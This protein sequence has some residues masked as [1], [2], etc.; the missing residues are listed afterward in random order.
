[1]VVWLPKRLI[2]IAMFAVAFNQGPA[3]VSAQS[4]EVNSQVSNDSL[5]KIAG[6]LSVGEEALLLQVDIICKPYREGS[7][8]LDRENLQTPFD[9][10]PAKV[11]KD[12]ADRRRLNAD[13]IKR[14]ALKEDTHA[15]APSGIRIIGAIF[16]DQLDLVGLE[17]RYSLV[18]DRSLFKS[19]INARNFRTKGDFS[20]D[21]SVVLKVLWLV[22]ARIDGTVFASSTF[23][24]NLHALESEVQRSLLFRNSV[25]FGIVEFDNLTVSGELSVR[26]SALSRF[27]MQSS[28]IG[29]VLDLSGSEARCAYHIK[30]SDFGNIIATDVGL[31]QV[32]AGA[33]QT[34]SRNYR[35]GW[36]RATTNSHVMQILQRP[37]VSSIVGDSDECKKSE[38]LLLDNHVRS[39]MCL[40][41][42]HWLTSHGDEVP[43]YLT[44]ND[45]NLGRSLIVNLGA[46]ASDLNNDAVANRVKAQFEAVGIEARNFIFDFAEGKPQYSLIVDGL[47]FE[48]AYSASI[49]CG[50]EPA[51]PENFASGADFV[52]EPRSTLQL[53][54]VRAVMDW[55]RNNPLATTQPLTAF[56]EAYHRAGD[57]VSSMELRIARADKELRTDTCVWL[58]QVGHVI[59]IR[60]SC[61]AS[62]AAKD[63]QSSIWTGLNWLWNGLN[64]LWAG[65]VIAFRWVLY[66]IA[67]HGYRPVQVVW[68]VL[69][70]LVGFDLY[71]WTLLGIIGFKSNGNPRVKPI[72]LLFLFDRLI[73]AYKIRDEHYNIGE[74]YKRAVHPHQNEILSKEVQPSV[75]HRASTMRYLGCEWQV[76]EAGER[77][78]RRVEVALDVLKIVGVGL[79]VFIAAAINALVAH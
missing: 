55:L 9:I 54:S 14:I 79:A 64:L 65:V 44:L 58:R 19:G 60:P 78:D 11:C 62:V 17:L 52:S 28:R 50:Y 15:V 21:D 56:V 43:S 36:R 71:F 4:A 35:Y 22:R 45:M 51:S 27:L 66:V 67:D 7:D 39:S 69:A 2:A 74:F 6:C 37:E 41:S 40:R 16:C 30:M 72:G 77:D 33:Q 59:G 25:L 8:Y 12:P 70:L 31:G 5:D 3:R 73:P 61:N 75:D 23:I 38:F 1:M 53:P 68:I 10:E 47:R 49:L 13:A 20:I 57:D 34:S 42:F 48:N 32:E 26:Q 18:L 24:Q 76:I 46:T 63:V 29:T